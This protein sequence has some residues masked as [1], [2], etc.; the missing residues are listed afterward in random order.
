MKYSE[1]FVKRVTDAVLSGVCSVRRLSRDLAI[2]RSTVARWAKRTAQGLPAR[3]ATKAKRVWNRST[4]ELLEQ[5][6]GLLASGRT[7]I[8]TWAELRKK[9]SMR[10]IQRWNSV[11]FPK[12]PK[13]PGKRYERR[14]AMS[15]MHTD[16]AFKRIKDGQKMRFS[17]YVDDA[18][19]KLYA[20]KAY[21]KASSENTVDC[22]WNAY[23]QSGG[24]KAL[25]TDRGRVYMKSFGEVCRDFAVVSIHTRPYNPK[26]NGKAEAV[27]KKVKRFLN[28]HEVQ[29]I[30]HANILFKQFQREYNRTPHSS[31]KYRTPLEVYRAKQRAGLIWAGG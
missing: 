28:N 14:K 22:L 5:A 4:D 12:Q 27:V 1:D 15:L 2:A 26:C 23:L 19:R 29:S 9:P 30:A 21:N 24:F 16:W 13:K 3:F 10:S 25:L 31:L 17:F 11:W 6:R 18:T 7:V 20:L 8:R